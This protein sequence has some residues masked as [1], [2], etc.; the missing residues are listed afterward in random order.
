MHGLPQLRFVDSRGKS[1]Q[2]LE[3]PDSFHLIAAD[4]WLG[5]GD[6]LAA[7]EELDKITPELRSHP[8]VLSVR[9]EIYARAKKW[10]GAA[11]IASALVKLMPEQP[12]FWICWAYATRRKTEGGIH[13]AKQ[14]LLEAEPKFPAEYLIRYNLACYECQ[15]GN[16]KKAMQWLELAIDLAGKKDIRT[17]ALNDPDLEKLWVNISEI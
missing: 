2:T 6:H 17:M 1:H 3:P 11:E 13:I 12:S 15:L 7:N 10:E 16:L 4:G 14:I 5:L 8:A 9:Y